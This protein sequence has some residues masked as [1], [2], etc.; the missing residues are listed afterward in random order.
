MKTKNSLHKIGTEAVIFD[1]DGLVVDTETP[2]YDAWSAIYREHGQ[3]LSLA[4]W[5]QCVGSHA[6][7]FDPVTH[8]SELVGRELDRA[9]LVQDKERRKHAV[10]L[11]QPLLPGVLDRLHESRSM[12]LRTAVASSSGRAW[13]EGHAMRLGIGELF[14]AVRTGDDVTR[15]K[16]HP[17]LY[18]AAAAALG[19]EPGRCVAFEDSL[20][21]VIA[22]KAAGMRCFAIPN[23]ITK[24][25][26]FAAADGVLTSLA[27]VTLADLLVKLSS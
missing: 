14:D 18:L 27:A 19:L 12:G 7:R 16:P 17:D 13:V 15:V 26:D 9:A 4:L 6:G 20:N 23:Q 21:G 2:A 1:F 24:G 3:E 22:A 8:L 11:T 5:V 25:L 10:C